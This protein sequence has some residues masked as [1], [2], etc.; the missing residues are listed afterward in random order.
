MLAAIALCGCCIIGRMIPLS[1]WMRQHNGVAHSTALRKAGYGDQA[2]RRAVQTGALIRLRRSW[3]VSPGCSDDRRAAAS[4]GGRITCVTAARELGLWVPESTEVH[5]AVAPTASRVASHGLHI[6][7]AQGP[8]PVST[9]SPEEPLLNVLFQ[10]ARCLAP[11]DALAVWE[12]A[13]RKRLV[14][15]GELERVRWHSSV[16]TNFASVASAL[17]DSGLETRFIWIM[18]DIGVSVRQQVRI[19]GRP[20]DGVI[21]ERLIVQID[22]FAHHQAAERRRD[23]EADARLV[24]LGYTVLRFDFYQVMFDP[25]Y[26]QTVIQTAIAQGLHLARRPSRT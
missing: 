22:G 21:G 13:I 12:S 4:A 24:L 15:P 9:R 16:A 14:T 1:V 2:V 10:T 3:L 18:R 6:H 8:A 26:V 17:S 20:V 11:P 23:I 19:D 25:G 5:I 7:W